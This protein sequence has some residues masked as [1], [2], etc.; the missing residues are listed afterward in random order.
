MCVKLT[1]IKTKL[2]IKLYM[3]ECNQILISQIIKNLSML[4]PK[5]FVVKYWEL[6]CTFVHF[7]FV[8]WEQ[9]LLLNY[10]LHTNMHK[11]SA[12]RLTV[13]IFFLYIEHCGTKH[14]CGA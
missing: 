5:P 8:F 1:D 12:Q 9:T 10:Y 11:T 4:P 13:P 7:C 6:L 3:Q 14:I 2:L